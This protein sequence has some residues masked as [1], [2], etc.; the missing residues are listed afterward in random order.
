VTTAGLP[1]E[2]QTNTDVTGASEHC[3][4]ANFREFCT[5]DRRKSPPQVPVQWSPDG[6]GAFTLM[7]NGTIGDLWWMPSDGLDTGTALVIAHIETC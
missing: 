6:T 5:Q 3:P 4:A 2:L 7:A 1:A